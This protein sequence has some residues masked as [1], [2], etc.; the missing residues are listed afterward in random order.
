MDAEAKV[1][2]SLEPL[3][4]LG[5]TTQIHEAIVIYRPPALKERPARGRLRELRQ[6][7][8]QVKAVA[9]AQRPIQDS[10][11]ATYQEQ[12]SKRFPGNELLAVSSIGA[13]TL[14][15]A[16]VEFTA[17]TLMSLAEQSDVLAVLPNERIDLIRP[18]A[19]NYAELTEREKKNGLTWGLE[20]LG[21]E[22]L[23]RT[24]KGRDINVAVMDTGVY[25]EHPA[26]AGR[27][28]DFIVIDPPGRRIRAT[29]PFDSGGHGTHVCGTI[30]GGRTP[31]GVAIG[32]AP[33]VNLFVA[34]VLLGGRGTMRS[35]LEGISWA[36]E[37]GADIISMSLGFRYY[38]PHFAVVFDMLI[39]QYGI[40]PVAAIGNE[41]Y[42]S[43]SSPGNAHNALAVGAVERTAGKS[44][45]VTFF[46]SGASL[47]F[48]GGEPTGLITKP[49]VVAPG[50]QVYSSIPPENRPQGLY[51]YS[52]MDGPSMATP[53]VAG[54]AALL[55]AAEPEAPVTEVVKALKETSEHPGGLLARPDNRWGYGLI[56]PA[57]ALA[58]LKS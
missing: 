16:T 47:V 24:T 26:L 18:T 55:L 31:E 32:V 5:D 40:V 27:V 28:R 7:L 53:H 13:G 50:V 23:W 30:A 46:S 8:R 2:P 38:E 4:T 1:S 39:E 41:N 21:I 37:K 36:V 54:V 33:E 43:S 57:E 52:Y 51:E 14:P 10:L 20:Q 3:L 29:P 42:G 6:R 15:I 49:D 45:N 34:S 11:L 9:A 58:A 22:A 48:P 44:P 12:G 19:V 25:G 35:L 17:G 56:R